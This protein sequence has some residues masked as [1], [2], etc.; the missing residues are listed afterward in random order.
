LK[1]LLEEFF[2]HFGVRGVTIARRAECGPLLV[3]AASVQL[4]KFP[5]GEFGLLHPVLARRYDLGDAALIAELNLDVM[6]AR[7]NTSRAFKPLAIH[8]S[9]S[10]DVAMLVPEAML[11]E[12][13]L[14]VV[15]Q[16]KPANLEAVELFDVFRGQ[17][18]PP[19]QKSVAYR[20]TYRSAERS[21]TDAEVNAANDKLVAQ[22]KTQLQA[23]V[24]E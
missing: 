22:L 6:L 7:R 18:V 21:L 16:A 15:K 14:Q 1:G 2:E 24:R 13:V 11:H 3:E 10:R 9:V 5:L 20:F 23:V 12:A 8:P 19:G 17:N 4:G